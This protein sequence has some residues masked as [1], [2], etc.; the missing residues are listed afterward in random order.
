[1]G[2]PGRDK[3]FSPVSVGMQAL[4]IGTALTCGSGWLIGQ[5]LLF[6]TD[7]KDVSYFH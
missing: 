6:W 1:M 3:T 2:T 5:G 4:I 7:S